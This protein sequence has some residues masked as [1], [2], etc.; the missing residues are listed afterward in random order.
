MSTIFDNRHLLTPGPWWSYFL[1]SNHQMQLMEE[2]LESPLLYNLFPRLCGPMNSWIR[3]AE[4]ARSMGFNWIYLNPVTMPGFSGSLYAVKDHYKVCSDFLPEGSSPDGL[5]ELRAVLASFRDLGLR[6]AMDLVVNHTAIDCP[7]VEQHPEWFLHDPDGRVA[8]PSAIDP[9]DARNVTVWG[10]LAEVDN[11]NS[12]DLDGLWEYWRTLIRF[13][14]ELGFEGYR[15]DAAYKVPAVLWRVLVD[16][17]RDVHAQ[18]TFFAE[19]LGCRIKEVRSLKGAGLDFLYNSSKY[20]RFDADWA[21]EQHESFGRIAPS[22]S[23]PE[24]HDTPRLFA[25]TGGNLDAV[26]QRYLFAAIFSQGVMVPVGFEFGFT[27]PLHVVSMTPGDWEETGVDLTG[28]IRGVNGL[29]NEMPVL[30]TE[31]H[32]RALG[33]YD[34]PT[35][36]LEKTDGKSKILV[37]INKDWHLGQRVKRETGW[38]DRLHGRELVRI[39]PT[40]ECKRTGLPDELELAPAEIVMMN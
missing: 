25:E 22:I 13:Y 14:T 36:V 28:F 29:K 11:Q 27:S 5:N 20:W 31:G 26:R 21:L 38:L 8:H 19:T 15:C 7:L 33:S 12:K 1:G 37:I 23:F 18:A 24:S 40:G 6:T 39:L 32:W 3:H 4:R 2:P 16:E 35:L 17:A 30:K 9:A 10:D 34:Q